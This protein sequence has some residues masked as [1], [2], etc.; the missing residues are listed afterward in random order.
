[1][2]INIAQNYILYSLNIFIFINYKQF[3][4]LQH[5]EI[6]TSSKLNTVKLYSW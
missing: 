4:Q 6:R 3:K 2:F 1:M 5:V